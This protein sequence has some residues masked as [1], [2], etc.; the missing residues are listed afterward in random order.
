MSERSRNSPRDDSVSGLDCLLLR[1]TGFCNSAR[2]QCELPSITVQYQTQCKRSQPNSS[3]PANMFVSKVKTYRALL[4][5]RCNRG[6]T[7]VVQARPTQV[8]LRG[9]R[10]VQPHDQTLGFRQRK[11]AIFAPSISVVSNSKAKSLSICQRIFLR[12][13][14]F[15]ARKC[16]TAS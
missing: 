13:G 6:A 16:L 4:I 11:A 14:S 5:W 10:P 7:Y 1:D 3:R 9:C 12:K 8:A 2:S 15:E